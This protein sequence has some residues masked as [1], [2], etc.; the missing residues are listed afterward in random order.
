MKVTL[1]NLIEEAGEDTNEDKTVDNE[2]TGDC[3]DTT[4]VQCVIRSYA[5]ATTTRKT[6]ICALFLVKTAQKL[7]Q[8]KEI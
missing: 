7:L 6:K 1:D 4:C 8:L 5:A 2:V 3:S